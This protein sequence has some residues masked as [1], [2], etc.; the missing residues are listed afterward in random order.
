MAVSVGY[1]TNTQ[2]HPSGT[3]AEIRPYRISVPQADVDDL[4]DRLAR[5]R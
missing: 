5:T 1:M 3:T 4:R 2:A